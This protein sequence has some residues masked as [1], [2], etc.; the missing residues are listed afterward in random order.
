MVKQQIRKKIRKLR[1]SQA[2]TVKKKNDLLIS[3]RLTRSSLF[4]RAKVIG[5]YV[6]NDSEVSTDFL[7]RY[8]NKKILVAPKTKQKHIHLYRLTDASS[9]KKGKF[10]I[11]EPGNHEKLFTD[12]KKIDLFIV[13]AIAFDLRGH[14]IGYGGGYFDRL[15]AKLDCTTIG[16]AYKLQIVDKIPERKYDVAVSYLLTEDQILLCKHFLPSKHR[17][18][19][20]TISSR[21]K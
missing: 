19:K 8:A 11:R 10:G 7:F 18:Q 3:R 6:S 15:L 5:F 13:P 1:E 17:I 20:S 21:E 4:K 14:R 9:L 16:L 12:Y 2:I